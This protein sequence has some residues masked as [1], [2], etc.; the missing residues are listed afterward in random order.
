MQRIYLRTCI[1]YTM[2]AIYKIF[3]PQHVSRYIYKKESSD[4]ERHQS[5]PPNLTLHENPYRGFIYPYFHFLI[6]TS[7]RPLSHDHVACGAAVGI[8]SV[9]SLDR[10]GHALH[11][12][13]RSDLTVVD[14]C[15]D[16]SLTYAGSFE[17]T[18]TLDSHNLH[19]A[20]YLQLVADLLARIGELAAQF[21][22]SSTR[23]RPPSCCRHA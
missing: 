18:A 8:Y 6:F 7:A 11:I 20:A 4:A 5:S 10:F 12:A 15:D 9:D 21:G 19:T 23:P 17:Q 22:C 14:V 13:D 16:E 2:T 1:S 3:A